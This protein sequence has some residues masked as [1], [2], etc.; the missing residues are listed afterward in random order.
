VPNFSKSP[1]KEGTNSRLF[2]FSDG[3]VNAGLT[4]KPEILRN[5]S[6]IY[7]K[8][9]VQI[10]AFGLGDDFDQELMKGIADKGIG[11]YF[12]IENSGAIPTFVE[13]ALKSVQQTVGTNA[14]IKA[15]GCNSGV[16]DKFYGDHNVVKGAVL[17]DLRADN[18]RTI[19]A[20]VKVAPTADSADLQQ[21]VECELT[22]TR[23]FEGIAKNYSITKFVNVM[24]TSESALVEQHANNEVKIQSAL[25]HI[26]KLDK[27]LADAMTSDNSDKVTSILQKEITL[28]ESVE[29]ID[30]DFFN[31]ENKVS[32]LL[33]QVK[34]N[35]ESFK[36]KGATKQQI[37]EVH[38]RGYTAAR[39]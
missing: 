29:K 38:H 22:Y 12:F 7:E 16:V 2:L 23:D 15:R 21:V 36:E 20:R 30:A 35:L 32:Q 6:D 37:K 18:T 31:G 4:S 39:G 25:Q 34:T 5:V 10:S 11:A 3:L 8:Q 26:V 28:L 9:N 14:V 33:K 27:K 24:V 1:K 17:G 13:F 19:M